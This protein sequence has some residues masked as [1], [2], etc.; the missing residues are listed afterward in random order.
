[1]NR[2]PL[3]TEAPDRF[4][5]RCL[6]PWPAS[7]RRNDL[8]LNV[9]EAAAYLGISANTL[10]VLRKKGIVAGYVVPGKNPSRPMWR[11]GVEELLTFLQR[12]RWGSSRLS[13]FSADGE[14]PVR[15]VAQLLGIS[16]Q[17]VR[18]ARWRGGLRDYT[19]DGVRCYWQRSSRRRIR[20][21]TKRIGKRL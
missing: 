9:S 5:F 20:E 7:H 11:V 8:A 10:R 2:N 15:V 6:D 12:H 3:A 13:D 17:A 14:L 4:L 19:A 21:K 1:M 18:I 16:E